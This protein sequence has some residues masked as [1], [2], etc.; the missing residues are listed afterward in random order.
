MTIWKMLLSVSLVA[1]ITMAARGEDSVGR[2]IT[3]WQPGMLD[4]H[5]ISSGRGNAGLYIF[6]DGTTLL[7]D[8]GELPFKTPKHTPDRPDGSRPAGE[9]IVRYIR[10]ALRHDPRPALDYALLTHFHLVIEAAH[11]RIGHSGVVVDGAHGYAHVVVQLAQRHPGVG[12]R[13]RIKDAV[14]VIPGFETRLEEHMRYGFA[15]ENAE[16]HLAEVHRTPIRPSR[17]GGGGP[18]S[19]H[20]PRAR[21]RASA[22]DMREGSRACGTLLPRARRSSS[23]RRWCGW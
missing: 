6:P 13:Q 9:W 7:V 16:I 2:E 14:P 4:I 12:F 19:R 10:H 20:V 5:Q 18:V 21:W 1:A 3:P 15:L 11:D 22:P 17:P 8:A 23:G